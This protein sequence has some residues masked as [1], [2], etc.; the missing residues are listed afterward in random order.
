LLQGSQDPAQASSKILLFD[1]RESDYEADGAFRILSNI[2][3]LPYIGSSYIAIRYRNSNCSSNWLTVGFDNIA[4][5]TNS[6]KID[7]PD[8]G[9]SNLKIYPN[10]TKNFIKIETQT[11]SLIKV[12]LLNLIGQPILSTNFYY[13]IQLDLSTFSEGT[14]FL[15]IQ[16]GD[17]IVTRKLI[18]Q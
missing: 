9:M 3:L 7:E 11:T 10:P 16:N 14:Y 18:K 1:F 17:H 6:L 2:S 15:K 4:I 13:Q 5:N 12:E 8:S